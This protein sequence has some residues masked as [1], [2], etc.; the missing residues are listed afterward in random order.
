MIFFNGIPAIRNHV[1]VA[2]HVL[3]QMVNNCSHFQVLSPVRFVAVSLM[4]QATERGTLSVHT[5]AKE[6]GPALFVGNQYGK[7]MFSVLNFPHVF[8]MSTIFILIC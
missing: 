2:V 6:S 3:D 7:G 5:E 4:T 1:F 8:L